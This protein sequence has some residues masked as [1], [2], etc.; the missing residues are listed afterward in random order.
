MVCDCIKFT[1]VA[2]AFSGSHKLNPKANKVAVNILVNLLIVL[3]SSRFN[4]TIITFYLK[5]KGSQFPDS[6]IF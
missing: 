4:K 6:Q 2:L 5:R 1:Q 3:S